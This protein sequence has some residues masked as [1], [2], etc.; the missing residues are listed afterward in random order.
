MYV[1]FFFGVAGA[2]VPGAMSVAEDVSTGS[3]SMSGVLWRGSFLVEDED[4]DDVNFGIK[5][6]GAS[7]TF[8]AVLGNG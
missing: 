1:S 7:V 4:E 3:I 8:E 2:A 6:I 5:T